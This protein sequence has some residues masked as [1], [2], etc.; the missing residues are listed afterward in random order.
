MERLC[1]SWKATD[2]VGFQAIANPLHFN[3]AGFATAAK[4]IHSAIQISDAGRPL[5]ANQNESG[6]FG[7][8]DAF[9][10]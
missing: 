8:W 10:R 3:I 7:L 2:A 5:P 1:V 6:I 4:T 9:L